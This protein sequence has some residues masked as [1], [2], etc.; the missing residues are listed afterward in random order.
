MSKFFCPICGEVR[1]PGYRHTCP[2]VW[3]VTLADDPEYSLQIQARNAQNAAEKFAA[4]YDE[5]EIAYQGTE[6]NVIVTRDGQ[7]DRTFTVECGFE[8]I[9]RASERLHAKEPVR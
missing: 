3:T 1:L 2:P 9:Y 5:G 7:P 6:L 4:S 8:P